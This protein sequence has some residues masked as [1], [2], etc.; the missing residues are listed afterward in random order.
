MKEILSYSTLDEEVTCNFPLKS[1]FK[2]LFKSLERKERKKKSHHLPLASFSLCPRSSGSSCF[3]GC[4][5]DIENTPRTLCNGGTFPPDVFTDEHDDTALILWAQLCYTYPCDD[6]ANPPLYF[7]VMGV[8]EYG[9]RTCV[10]S[11]RNSV[12][13]E[14]SV[15]ESTSGVPSKKPYSDLRL[16]LQNS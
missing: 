10:R 1:Y 12:P 15:K 13:G 2:L 6:Q 14:G 16:S 8:E 5:W 11:P 4:S 9:P 7:P 3:S